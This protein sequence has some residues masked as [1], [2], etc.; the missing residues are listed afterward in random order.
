VVLACGSKVFYHFCC[1]FFARP[2]EKLATKDW[3]YHRRLISWL[4]CRGRRRSAAAW[5]GSCLLQSV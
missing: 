5:L 3:I 1:Q 2:G 4:G